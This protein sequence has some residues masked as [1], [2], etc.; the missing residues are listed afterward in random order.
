M[1]L[2]QF[3]S[4][5]WADHATKAAD[6]AARLPQA[7]SLVEKNEQIPALAGLATHVFGEHLG[8]W[9]QGIE[10]LNRLRALPVFT[11][12]TE[13]DNALLRSVAALEVAGG[14]KSSLTTFADSDRIRVLAVAASALA[15]LERPADGKA[16]FMQALS[17]AKGLAKTDPANRA[18]AV[19][20]NNLAAGLELK[21]PRTSADTELML[22]AAEIG[23][24]YWEIAG[25]WKEMAWAEYRW[26]QSLSRAGRGDEARGHAEKMMAIWQQHDVGGAMEAFYAFEARAQAEKAAGQM[27]AFAKFAG[28]AKTWYFKLSPEDQQW[29]K[30]DFDRLTQV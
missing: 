20:G 23:R 8:Q 18:L 1:S 27:E 16:L 15:G 10:Y 21:T 11:A 7:L 9:K 2:D 24:T 12:G 19:T 4:Q 25:T 29:C 28:E 6:V 17:L 26:A 13:S 3:L 22:L 14:D 5:G 30:A